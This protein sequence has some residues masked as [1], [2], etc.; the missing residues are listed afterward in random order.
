MFGGGNGERVSTYNYI[1]YLVIH[2]DG[3]SQLSEVLMYVNLSPVCMFYNIYYSNIGIELLHEK[4]KVKL[5]YINDSS[6]RGNLA[7]LR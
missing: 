3:H 7:L 4:R 6:S 5:L 1:S 2:V